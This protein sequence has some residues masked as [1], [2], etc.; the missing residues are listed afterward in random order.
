MAFGSG[1]GELLL[2]QH[3][4]GQTG[5]G[6]VMRQAFQLRLRTL[7]LAVT[8]PQLALLAVDLCDEQAEQAAA[9][10]SEPEQRRVEQ[11][12]VLVVLL[13]L[14]IHM[15]KGHGH[16]D[17]GQGNADRQQAA[18]GPSQRAGGRFLFVGHRGMDGVISLQA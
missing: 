10:Q 1:L 4:V 13:A 9:S 7:Q 17:T 6:V 8:L 5:D 3:P 14:D 15:P 12:C 11:A 2:E 16:A 18:K